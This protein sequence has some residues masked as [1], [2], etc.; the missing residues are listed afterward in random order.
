MLNQSAEYA[1]RAVLHLSTLPQGE[2]TAASDIAQHTRV[3]L[4]Y[5]QKILRLLTRAGLLTAR[6]GTGGGFTLAIPGE[7][8]SILQVLEVCDASP[9]RI[10]SCPLGIEGHTQLCPLHHLID[11]QIANSE[12]VFAN[13]T[14]A[15][16][17]NASTD[18][19]P[20]CSSKKDSGRGVCIHRDSKISEN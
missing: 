17:R 18:L 7:Q 4:H 5:L 11:Q 14:I 20:L 15:D 1:L 9:Q 2:T 6:R 10:E 8:I 16:L 12:R 19:L 13:T 3:P